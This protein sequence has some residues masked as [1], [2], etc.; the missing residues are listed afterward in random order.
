M[1]YQLNNYK[2]VIDCKNGITH[3]PSIINYTS[4]YFKDLYLINVNNE[5]D[6]ISFDPF[7]KV[8]IVFEENNNQIVINY[9]NSSSHKTI[10]EYENNS[11]LYTFRGDKNKINTYIV[12]SKY[13]A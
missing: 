8:M 5:L 13:V 2:L 6:L 10:F 4:Q 9:P 7:E 11:L 3:L 1:P 12:E